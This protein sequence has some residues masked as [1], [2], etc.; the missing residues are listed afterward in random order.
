MNELYILILLIICASCLLYYYS[1]LYQPMHAEAFDQTYLS[2]CPTGYKTTYHTSGDVIC[3][4]GEVIA[5]KCMGDNP[6]TLN[7]QAI[8]DIPSCLQAIKTH[9]SNKGDNLCPATMPNYYENRSTNAKGCTSGDLNSTLT[10]PSTTTQ[11]QCSLYSTYNDSITKVD[12]CVLLKERDSFP[13]FGTNCKKN[14]ISIDSS[15]P[16]VIQIV[17]TYNGTIYTT[18]TR[19][20]YTRYLDANNPSW[21]DTGL[22]LY[23]NINIAEVAKAVYIDQTISTSAAQMTSL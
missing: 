4:N 16:A 1:H 23:A 2:S 21:R 22:D 14:I 17:F 9:F 15:K 18:Y 7:N 8:G 11:P 19:D 20:S 3:C 13:C 12:S 10:G 6:C 5:N